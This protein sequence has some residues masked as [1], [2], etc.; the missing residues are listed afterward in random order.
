MEGIS[1][2]DPIT[3]TLLRAAELTAQGRSGKAVALLRPIAVAHPEQPE[4]WCR[5]A[6]AHLD[7]GEAADALMAAKRAIRLGGDLSWANQLASRARSVLSQPQ[8]SPRTEMTLPR[9]LRHPL[10]QRLDS[11]QTPTQPARPPAP[12]RRR[13]NTAP[14]ESLCWQAIRQLT[15]TM[16]SAGMLLLV[17]GLPKPA[18]VLSWFGFGLAVILFVMLLVA[19]IRLPST[20]RTMLV[21]VVRR[22]PQIGIAAGLFGVSVALLLCWSTLV[23]SG[24]ATAQPLIF[25]LC[26]AAAGG[27]L[28]LLPI[29]R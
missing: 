12:K 20:V 21:D 23:Q 6:A 13:V 4:V 1:M 24:A 2:A 26:C 5:L 27:G 28:S 16:V 18:P 7:R 19:I 17:A 8:L 25:S 9:S 14:P 15:M 29:N 11:Q 22:W 10:N 3:A